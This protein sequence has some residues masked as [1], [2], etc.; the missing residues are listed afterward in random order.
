MTSQV[1]K[2]FDCLEMKR[3]AQARIFEEIQDM[4]AQEQIEYF[5]HAIHS[6]RFR[7]WW[8]RAGK[9]SGGEIKQAS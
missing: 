8:E 3:D 5:R 2:E 4:S 7:E 9:P 1:K 6:S